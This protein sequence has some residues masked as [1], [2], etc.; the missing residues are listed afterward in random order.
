M[1]KYLK[2]NSIYRHYVSLL[3]RHGK[4]CG[5]WEKWCKE[6]KTK[7]DR[8]EIVVGAILTQRTNWRN[9]ELAFQNLR[10]EEIL[11]I[12]GIEQA[13]AKNIGLLER[14]IRP[15]GF[16]RQKAE[17]LFG[18]CRYINGVHGS[19]KNFFSQNLADCREQLLEQKGVGP[20]T[21]D[22][23]LLYAGDKPIFVIDEY[24]RRFVKKNGLGDDFSYGGLQELFEKNL[25]DDFNLYQDFHALIVKEGKS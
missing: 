1:A 15:A 19:L 20:E 4:P 21:A 2:L 3:K 14:L 23:I 22:S 6:K 12:K 11:S 13:G 25:P 5:F 18:L 17:R 7:N 8:E 9:V 16:Y 24:T 10:K